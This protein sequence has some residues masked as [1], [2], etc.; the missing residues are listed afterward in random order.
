MVTIFP[1]LYADISEA[2]RDGMC[3]RG[4]AHFLSATDAFIYPQTE[5]II[6]A[7]AFPG[8]A[9]PHLLTPEG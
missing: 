3:Y 4:I 1:D 7:F 8:E 9:Y 5:W 6:S 2:C